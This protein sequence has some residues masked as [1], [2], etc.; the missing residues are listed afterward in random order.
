[1]Q[2]SV[3]NRKFDFVKLEDGT[4]MCASC[5]SNSHIEDEQGRCWCNPELEI[6]GENR[7]WIHNRII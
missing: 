4:F 2:C 5:I 3:C 1:M 6:V 7:I